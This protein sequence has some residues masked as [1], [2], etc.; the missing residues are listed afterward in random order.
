MSRLHN[1]F[2]LPK[3]FAD[4]AE[5]VASTP[6]DVVHRE[7][8][9]RL[10]RYRVPGEVEHRR[11]VLIVPSLINRHYVLDLLPD[12]SF[13][14]Y[15]A[16][17]GHEVYMLDW[18]GERGD[19]DRYL[20][21]DEICDDFVRRARRAACRRSDA[22]RLHVLGYCLGGTITAIHAARFPDAFASHVALAA[23][24]AF[25][26]DG[27][28]TT[29]MNNPTFDLDSLVD[30]TRNVPWPL[31]QFAFHM[32][33]PTMNLKKMTYLWEKADDEDFLDGFAALE[34]WGNDNVSF[35]G[36]AF[37]GYIRRLYRENRLIRG[38]FALSG[39][40]ISLSDIDHPTLVISFEHDHIVPGESA[41]P[42]ADAV[43]TDEVEHLH[44]PG[45]HVTSVTSTSAK[46]KL[47]PRISEWFARR[48]AEQNA[49]AAE[50]DRETERISAAAG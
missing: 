50:T 39:W 20:G 8:R 35:P 29:W 36:E 34:I 16:E 14:G 2:T 4:R 24:V 12:R 47:W 49:G 13:V 37:R 9:W 33:Q 48:N 3:R 45:G 42:L 22:D 6:R 18:G 5:D 11:P 1:L 43:G 44:L 10:L 41:A 17:Q 19:E 28:L 31:M 27:K 7:S 40:P 25:D 21:L 30:A 26:D 38:E 32:L 46:E 23:P 15:L